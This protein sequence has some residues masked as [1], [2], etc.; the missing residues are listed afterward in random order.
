MDGRVAARAQSM[1]LVCGR[2]RKTPIIF[3]AGDPI[4]QTVLPRG[5]LNRVQN[6]HDARVDLA[7]LSRPDLART[8]GCPLCSLRRPLLPGRVP[9][10]VVRPAEVLVRQF[11]VSVS[12]VALRALQEDHPVVRKALEKILET[13]DAGGTV[14]DHPPAAALSLPHDLARAAH[15]SPMPD[16]STPAESHSEG[17]LMRPWRPSRSTV[18]F[19]GAARSRTSAAVRVSRSIGPLTAWA[20]VRFATI[21]SRHV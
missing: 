5:A 10:Q 3:E 4:G 21:S 11:A 18:Y 17:R 15:P 13:G 6:G 1:H 19:H 14:N 8:R 9:E 16:E 12:L 7:Q 2:R 20:A